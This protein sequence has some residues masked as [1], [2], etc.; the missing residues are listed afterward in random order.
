[1]KLRIEM[2]ELK[3]DSVTTHWSDGSVTNEPYQIDDD[4]NEYADLDPNGDIFGRA[5]A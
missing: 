5:I 2:Q 3:E 4:G 1:M